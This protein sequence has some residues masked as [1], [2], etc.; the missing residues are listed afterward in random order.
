MLSFLFISLFIQVKAEYIFYTPERPNIDPIQQYFNASFDVIQNEYYFTQDHYY[1][2]HKTVLKRIRSP[3][4]SIKNDGGYKKL[5][6]DEFFG[7]RVIPNLTLHLTGG[8]YDKRLLREYFIE[9]HAKYPRLYAY[10]LA[11]LGHLGNES[12][13]TTSARIT[14]HDHIADLYFFDLAS[15]FLAESDGAL[16]FLR[17]QMGMMHWH[18]RPH[19]NIKTGHVTNAGLNYVFRPQILENKVFLYLGMQNMIGYSHQIAPHDFLS[20]GMGLSLTDPLEDKGRFVVGLFYDRNKALTSSLFLNGSEDF[21]WRLN[22]YPNL[23][24]G[25]WQAS[26]QASSRF[27]LWR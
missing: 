8:A 9:H 22:L 2:K 21:R 16:I 18:M 5:F 7:K 13:E 24:Q 14:S 17:D 19:I 10:T 23:F 15:I 12:L 25:E 11:Y 3:H 26:I 4:Q 1:K 6:Q 27:S 20:L